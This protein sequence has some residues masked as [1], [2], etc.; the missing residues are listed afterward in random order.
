MKLFIPALGSKFVLT[1]PWTFNLHDEYRNTKFWKA[2]HGEADKEVFYYGYGG[3]GYHTS[4]VPTAT[5]TT[6]AFKPAK[7]ILT[8]FPKGTVLW[9]ERIYI[10]KGAGD[11]D[12]MSF[13]IT[14]G[15][16][17]PAGRFW[18][19]LEDING[20]LDVVAELIDKYP[21]GKFSIQIEEGTKYMCRC[22]GGGC[23]CD[24]TTW[25][26]FKN[27]YLIW[28]SNPNGSRH[29]GRVASVEHSIDSTGKDDIT[30][31]NYANGRPRDG[32]EKSFDNME[33]LLT[34][35]QKKNLTRPHIDT[36]IARYEE[37]KAQAATDN[38]A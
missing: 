3:K 35:A 19:K 16:P 33:D 17:V 37:K 8:T 28:V 30:V 13:R 23:Q 29:G 12:S 22:R 10:R 14:K 31:E 27:E 7:P 11:F 21:N 38:E 24:R 18:V 15:G 20:K 2:L 4:P 9:L 6:K 1:K 5:A 32:Y 25:P 36:F 26:K 34:W